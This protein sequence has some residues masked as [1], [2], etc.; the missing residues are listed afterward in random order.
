MFTV[1]V[2]YDMANNKNHSAKT[3]SSNQKC[4]GQFAPQRWGQFDW[5]F[6]SEA[7]MRKLTENELEYY[8]PT[9][10]FDIFEPIF[11]YENQKYKIL[12]QF[13]KSEDLIFL[14]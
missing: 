8:W 7:K 13:N 6:H 14:G 12:F 5:N 3:V 9:I 10:N 11:I 2:Y 1:S 4:R